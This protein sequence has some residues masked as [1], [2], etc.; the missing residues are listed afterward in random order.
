MR[1]PSPAGV[2]SRHLQDEQSESQGFAPCY[3]SKAS[4]NSW[5]TNPRR[6]PTR[7]SARTDS[8]TEFGTGGCAH[9]GNKSLNGTSFNPTLGPIKC[10]IWIVPNKRRN[11][12]V[13][14]SS[15]TSRTTGQGTSFQSRHVMFVF[16][17]IRVFRRAHLRARA[18]RVA[19]RSD[20]RTSES[21]VSVR[22]GPSSFPR[23]LSR[24]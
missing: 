16:A 22:S 18:S 23:A 1:D 17:K 14:S 19:P 3:S 8:G 21:L 12:T 7:K 4:N 15:N 2:H 13:A 20:P 6:R 10:A 11:S 9:A 24:A 5:L